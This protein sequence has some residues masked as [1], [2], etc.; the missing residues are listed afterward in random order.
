MAPIRRQTEAL[1]PKV[2]MINAYDEYKRDNVK[3]NY[4]S[5]G[6]KSV[7]F[8]DTVVRFIKDEDPIL[9][10]HRQSPKI[11]KPKKNLYP[12]NMLP[13]EDALAEWFRMQRDQS[14]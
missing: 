1:S 10:Y 4:R 9:T 3:V 6:D 5:L 7:V 11:A 13:I 14:E 8:E 2:K 12:L